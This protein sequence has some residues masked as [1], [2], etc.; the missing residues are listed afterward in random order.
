MLQVGVDVGGTFTDFFVMSD[1]GERQI[2]KANSVPSDPARAVV[3]GLAEIASIRDLSLLDFLAQVQTIVHG[4]TVTTNALLER[5]GA[6]VGL[7]TTK[8]F[9]DVLALREGTREKPYD[10]RS[11]APK[12]LVPRH[13]RL[14]VEERIDVDGREARALEVDEVRYSAALLH[15]HGADSVAV[16][17]MHSWANPAH[18]HQALEILTRELP[19]VYLCNSA[20]I[21]PRLG[22]YRRT[23]TAVLTAYV[24]PIIRRYLETLRRSLEDAGF[25]GLLLLMQS[26]GG[27]ATSE[28]LAR[29]A[30][31][32]ILS[33]P[34]AAPVA[35]LAHVAEHFW[36][37]CLTVDMGG[38]SFDV[39]VALE[40]K[41]LVVSD[42]EVGGWR[43]GLPMV[44]VSTIGAGGGSIA[45][46]DSGGLLRV[47]PESAGAVPGPACYGRGG[48]RAT[49]TDADLVLGYLSAEGFLS[50]GVGLDP[51]RARTALTRDVAQP[52]GVDVFDAAAGVYDVINANMA[53]GISELTSRR[54]LDLREFP[55]VV[56]GGAGPLHA[57]AIALEFGIP[58]LIIPRE[59]SI[60]CATGLLMCDF[61]HDYECSYVTSL[62]K[63]D[64]N[65]LIDTWLQ[66]AN[67]GRRTLCSEG[68]ESDSTLFTPSLDLRYA[69]QWH[70][71]TVP[72]HENA[73]QAC[74]IDTIA[75]AFNA[76]HDKLFGY[77]LP[78]ETIEVLNARITAV[79][80]TR[81]RKP[82]VVTK[83]RNGRV[84]PQ[85]VRPM[86]S[87]AQRQMVPGPVFDGRSLSVGDNV[88]G[89]AIIEMETTSIVVLEQFDALVD[90]SDAIV[91]VN[92][93]IHAH[94]TTQSHSLGAPSIPGLHPKCPKPV[95][96]P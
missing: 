71:L 64:P 48:D 92:R 58:S 47:G 19:G 23:S 82:Q 77:S 28:E 44:D 89:P 62:D 39:T 41:P 35:G 79:G 45:F 65:H 63:L 57:A 14:P 24:G 31:L 29:Q 13:L 32:S 88:S 50:G 43:I 10:N 66:M 90:K 52:L 70:E 95:T 56:A 40:N 96:Q 25:H 3:A 12:P 34:A 93:E 87:L 72:L 83:R 80:L 85:S 42:G 33:G 27:I 4:T 69:G 53:A 59:S 67:R 84:K 38:T 75:E 26:N 16:A 5:R 21:L 36:D 30:A 20:D 51:E 7:L 74:A 91:L 18:E 6:K 46:V 94:A 22:Y 1:D 78:G 54:G 61:K 68:I 81:R 49:V 17:F 8:G 37:R 2:Y 55:F 73:L 15:Q 11:E 76:L 9:R 86:W 60:F